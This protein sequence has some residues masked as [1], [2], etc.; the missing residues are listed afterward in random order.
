MKG[1]NVRQAAWIA[2]SGQRWKAIKDSDGRVTFQ[3]A[4]G[5]A[6]DIY[7]GKFVA[8]ANIDAW[9]LNNSNAQKWRLVKVS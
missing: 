4:V 5:T 9:T 3:S 2:V 7:G 8:G 1:T 6:L